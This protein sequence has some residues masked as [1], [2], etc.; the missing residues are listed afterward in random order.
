MNFTLAAHNNPI[1]PDVSD[2][3]T[4]VTASQTTCDDGIIPNL[5]I[6]PVDDDVVRLIRSSST[7]QAFHS[8]PDTGDGT[9]SHMEIKP[10]VS[11]P[12]CNEQFSNVC[13]SHAISLCKNL[14]TSPECN[15]NDLNNVVGCETSRINSQ[16]N[17][18]ITASAKKKSSFFGKFCTERSYSQTEMTSTAEYLHKTASSPHR[19]YSPTETANDMCSA[20]CN[21]EINHSEEM[22]N[23]IKI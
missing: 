22:A 5:P 17:I 13:D 2:L 7:H 18:H 23:N 11:Q 14:D 16:E 9:F 10:E 1:Y 21:T 12:G 19:P 3:A 8:V 20:V 6:M 15:N 4:S